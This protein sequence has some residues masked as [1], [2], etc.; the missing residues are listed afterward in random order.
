MNYF[1][2]TIAEEYN[3]CPS[4]KPDPWY[5]KDNKKIEIS[6]KKET[7]KNVNKAIDSAQK[8]NDEKCRS[9]FGADEPDPW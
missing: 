7:L 4:D 6:D 5:D 1:I 8:L 3:Y 2:E 9:K